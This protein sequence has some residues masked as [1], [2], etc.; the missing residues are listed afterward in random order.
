MLQTKYNIISIRL[1]KES[2]IVLRIDN[3]ISLVEFKIKI[4]KDGYNLDNTKDKIAFLKKITDILSNVDN[5]IER[6]IYI[7]KISEQY[8]ISR[9]AL[10]AEINK[11]LYKS[12]SKNILVKPVAKKENLAN[13]EIDEVTKKRENMV[14]Y[15]LIN[16]PLETKEVIRSNITVNDFKLNE[17]K[18]IFEEGKVP[19]LEL[20][21]IDE[22]SSED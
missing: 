9:Q 1:V 17:N 21:D 5:K 11:V 15:L 2:L 18:V 6:E 16:N 10:Y 8:D 3:A 20:S 14:L 19:Y 13:S 4:L 7:D 12:D 22:D